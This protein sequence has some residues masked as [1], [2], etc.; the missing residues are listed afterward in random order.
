MKNDRDSDSGVQAARRQRD[1][2]LSIPH[3]YKLAIHGKKKSS[4]RRAM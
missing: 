2:S 4:L 3:I 1:K